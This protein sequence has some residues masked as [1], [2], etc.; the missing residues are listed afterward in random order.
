MVYISSSILKAGAKHAA[1]LADT[2]FKEEF[3]SV[4]RRKKG[5]RIGRCSE[6]AIPS[7]RYDSYASWKVHNSK[8]DF[9]GRIYI[10]HDASHAYI[11]TILYP[12]EQNDVMLQ[13]RILESLRGTYEVMLCGR[14]HVADTFLSVENLQYVVGGMPTPLGTSPVSFFG[15]VCGELVRDYLIA[16]K[17][18]QRDLA[19]LLKEKS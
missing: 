12:R 16:R 7:D 8:R 14:P 15:R 11:R 10:K 4:V 17:D 2:V 6:N 18:A 19:A 5:F 13:A 9:D 1:N 3:F